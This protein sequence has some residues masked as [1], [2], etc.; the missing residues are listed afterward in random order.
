ME[1]KDDNNVMPYNRELF[2]NMSYFTDAVWVIDVDS[3]TVHVLFDKFYPD[4]TGRSFSLETIQEQLSLSCHPDYIDLMHSYYEPEFLQSLKKSFSYENKYF[5]DSSYHTMQ[6]VMTPAQNENGSNNIVYV[7]TRDI[8]SII[9]ERNRIE[10]NYQDEY[11]NISNCLNAAN[12]GLWYFILKDG[13]PKFHIDSTTAKIVGVKEGLHPEDNYIF[14]YDRI[15]SEYVPK[16]LECINKMLSGKPAEVIYPYNHPVRGKI[17]VRCGGILD[18]NHK[19]R[20]GKL[21]GYH[22]DISEYNDKL[23]REIE[24][25]NALL[26]NFYTV[27]SINLVE[28]T[29]KVLWDPNDIYRNYIDENGVMPFDF[30]SF[31]YDISPE[32]LGNFKNFTSTSKLRTILNGKRLYSAEIETISSGWLRVTMIPSYINKEGILDRVVFLTEHIDNE[33]KEELKMANLLK[34]TMEKKDYEFYSLKSIASVYLSM[35]LLDF[36]TNELYEI[37]ATESI[38]DYM[39]HYRDSSVQ[40]LLWGI[41]RHR[42]CAAHREEALKFADL[43]TLYERMKGKSDISL[44]V[45]NA[46]DL[47]VRFSFVRDQAE[48]NELSKIVFISRII[49]EIKRKEEHLV[50]MSNTDELTGLYN[51]HAYEDFVQKS[52]D[53]GVAENLWLMGV[54]VNGL[55]VTNDTKGHK[56]GDEL[57]VGVAGILNSAISSFGTVYR[58]GGDEFVV[59][60]YGTEKEISACLERMQD[61]KNKWHGE[62]SENL[63]FS[64]GLVSAKEFPDAGLAELEKEADRRMYEDKRSYYSSSTGDRRGSRK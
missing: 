28:N 44:E 63:S 30:N 52:E 24:L 15:E 60:L 17:T 25:S 18:K 38:R 57:I 9:D 64:K 37:K 2:E 47:W 45:I 62:F 26:C 22:Q 3:R 41:L 19:G 11:Q 16:V 61:N 59:I 48:T 31:V 20:G 6:C 7:T 4:T 8:Q 49:D 35:H 1:Q 55:K 27:V 46:D 12:L 5:I 13:T 34:K 51:R 14:W 33:K 40:E 58:V 36:K 21:R 39:Q 56:A 54:D 42:V 53:E 23:L 32:S 29:V 10:K 50:L 43:S